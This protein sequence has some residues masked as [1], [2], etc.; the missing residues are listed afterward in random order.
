MELCRKEVLKALG[1][2]V[3]THLSKTPTPGLITGA[4]ISDDSLVI[5]VKVDGVTHHLDV[6]VERQGTEGDGCCKEEECDESVR[7]Q[8]K[9]SSGPACECDTPGTP[10]SDK[11]TGAEQ[12]DS[13]KASEDGDEDAND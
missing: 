5:D 9:D 10:E 8:T 4:C 7:S 6:C 13:E 1:E 12:D 2:C 11:A 3:Q